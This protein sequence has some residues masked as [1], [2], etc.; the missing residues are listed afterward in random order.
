LAELDR[1]KD[2]DTA[3]AGNRLLSAFEVETR[4]LIEA[5]ATIVELKPGAILFDSGDQV[6]ASLFPFGA[7]SVSLIVDLSSGRS[8][9]VASIGREGAVGGI[10]SC[11]H[12]PAF[13]RAEV[14]V[15]GPAL[16]IPM[17]ALEEAKRQSPFIANLFCR[18]S[19][20]LLAQLM[21]SVACNLFHSIEQRAARWLLIA[22][23]R[24]GDHIEMTQDELAKLLGA[25]RTTVNAVER[26]FQED[27]L[28]ASRRGSVQVTDR[29]GLKRRS[30]GCYDA[31][32]KHFGNVIG[33]HGTGAKDAPQCI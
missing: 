10:V 2:A 22:Q 14:Q 21:Q 31:V 27:G 25:Q 19:D 20:Y 11:G 18:Y 6:K 23:D 4:A 17:Q 9:E 1:V 12:A 13:S 24:S 8:V 16:K 5:P 29:D 28:I 3:F 32:E 7:T 33:D 26:A 30:C 15:G